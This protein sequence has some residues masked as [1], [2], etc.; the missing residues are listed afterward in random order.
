MAGLVHLAVVEFLSPFLISVHTW[1]CCWCSFQL[2]LSGIFVIFRECE[3]KNVKVAEMG[4]WTVFQKIVSLEREI[5]GCAHWQE[6]PIV[7]C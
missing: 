5:V 6:F 2:T 7:L 3:S 1:R 4:P